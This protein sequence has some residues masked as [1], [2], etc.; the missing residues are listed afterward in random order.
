MD[1]ASRV[2]VLEGRED[3]GA[4][5]AGALVVE[6]AVLLDELE[7]LAVLGQLEHEIQAALI[8]ERPV[9]SDHAWMP[10]EPIEG[11]FLDVDVLLLALLWA[12]EPRA[13][14]CAP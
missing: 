13:D 8:V 5:E 9:E 14:D 3:L 6:R 12:S 2:D 4:V 7:D 10:I 11:V 1:D